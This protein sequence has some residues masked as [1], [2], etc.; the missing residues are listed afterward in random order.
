MGEPGAGKT[1]ILLDS[2]LRPGQ[3][4]VFISNSLVSLEKKNG[5]THA[6]GYPM[7]VGVRGAALKAM[8]ENSSPHVLPFFNGLVANGFLDKDGR[9]HM[10]PAHLIDHFD[11]RIK[12]DTGVDAIVFI[13]SIAYGEAATLEEVDPRDHVQFFE[14]YF[15]RYYDAD[16]VGW[17]RTLGV[18]PPDQRAL[19]PEIILNSKIL[20]LSYPFGYLQEAVPLLDQI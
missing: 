9:C 10:D 20:L 11:R 6:Y 3:R 8:S 2:L 5:R 16:E 18:R 17:Y 14:D 7:A 13:K 15:L 1:S 19:I 4:S 12:A